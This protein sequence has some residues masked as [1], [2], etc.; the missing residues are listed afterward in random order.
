MDYEIIKYDAKKI[1][2]SK[3]DINEITAIYEESFPNDEKDFTIDQILKKI[4]KD[5]RLQLFIL[6]A[7]PLETGKKRVVSFI[8]N[9]IDEKF[10]YTV[11]LAAKKQFGI[12]GYGKKLVKYSMDELGKNK[13]KFFLA[14]K[15]EDTAENKEQRRRRQVYF[16][17]F[18]LYETGFDTT[19]NGVTFS[20]YAKGEAT[21]ED[22]YKY[23]KIVS[24]V[25]YS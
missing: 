2:V 20:T 10:V 18:G 17:R 12:K 21:K 25:Y 19:I 24:E 13:F 23:S 15:V 9:I 16:H 8:L 11:F 14:E 22:I 7:D 1:N 3:E 5:D 6:Y 4:E